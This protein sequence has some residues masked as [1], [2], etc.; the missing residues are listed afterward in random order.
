MGTGRTLSRR[1]ESGLATCLMH[2]P[3]RR[4]EGTVSEAVSLSFRWEPIGPLSLDSA[5]KLV[6]P[7]VP[8]LPG[9]YRFDLDGEGDSVYFGEAADLRQRFRQYRNPGRTQQT[10]LRMGPLLRHVVGAGGG[11]QVSL[12]RIKSFEAEQPTL[13][14]DMRLK[15]A[16]VLI[17]SAAIVLARGDGLRTVLNLDKSFDRSLGDR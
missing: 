11:C 15:A 2:C 4:S 1:P 3:S 6:F 9:V 7:V 14:L 8:S 10:N 13:Q 17:E 12:A 5:G 16:R